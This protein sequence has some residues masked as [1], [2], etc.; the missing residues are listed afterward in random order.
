MKEFI[1]QIEEPHSIN[2]HS[3]FM[4]SFQALGLMFSEPRQFLLLMLL[5]A[6]IIFSA[7]I[8]LLMFFTVPAFITGIAT[9]VIM[10]IKGKYL[11]IKD[12]LRYMNIKLGVKVSSFAC[13]I[14]LPL[15]L[16]IGSVSNLYYHLPTEGVKHF[17]AMSFYFLFAALFISLLWGN[18]IINANILSMRNNGGLLS[19]IV[20]SIEA[21][22]KNPVMMFIECMNWFLS[23]AFLYFVIFSGIIVIQLLTN[24]AGYIYTLVLTYLY[25]FTVITLFFLWYLVN[26]TIISYQML[27]SCPKTTE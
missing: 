9:I 4:S 25:I 27:S 16:I 23:L 8:P 19:S 22:I 21:L 20:E 18:V 5:S 13:L 7:A 17:D 2:A 1:Q 15:A 3:V 12:L 14:L 11:G 6:G 24:A 10:N 26:L